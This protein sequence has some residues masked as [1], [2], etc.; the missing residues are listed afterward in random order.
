MLTGLLNSNQYRH[1]LSLHKY[2]GRTNKVFW[3]TL[4]TFYA[5]FV[6]LL[7]HIYFPIFDFPLNGT[8]ISSTQQE[9]IKVY[10]VWEFSTRFLNIHKIAAGLSVFFLSSL[11]SRSIIYKSCSHD[12]SK[13]RSS[14]IW[15]LLS[16]ICELRWEIIAQWMLTFLFC[17]P[18][19]I[20]VIQ[21]VLT[22]LR[23]EVCFI[24]FCLKSNCQFS[25]GFMACGLSWS[26]FCK[27]FYYVMRCNSGVLVG[28]SWVPF[29]TIFPKKNLWNIK[30]GVIWNR[31]VV[32]VSPCGTF[33]WF[34]IA[35]AIIKGQKTGIIVRVF[36]GR[37]TISS[38]SDTSTSPVFCSPHLPRRS[39]SQHHLNLGHHSEGHFVKSPSEK[40]PKWTN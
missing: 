5:V 1:Y 40:E 12:A 35:L 26:Q 9:S 24:M 31:P 25:T 3:H 37:V 18:Y 6:W 14:V 15:H 39:V 38:E 20:F 28:F 32:V 8:K 7:G 36:T 29:G 34:I 30:S 4:N 10:A 33:T 13:Q 22:F 11:W 23:F 27:T 16:W 2:V 19:G 21:F 17:T